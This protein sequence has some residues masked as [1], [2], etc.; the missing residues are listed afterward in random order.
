MRRA[1]RINRFQTEEPPD[2][3]I[4]MHD[5]IARRHM[6]EVE[7]GWFRRT[8]LNQPELAYLWVEPPD[9]DREL[10][11]LDDADWECV[12]RCGDECLYELVSG[13]GFG[14]RLWCCCTGLVAEALFS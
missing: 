4:E 13:V 7:R 8:L 11:P 2:A 5:K 6:A 3:V 9:Y 12:Y 10:A 14:W 1:G